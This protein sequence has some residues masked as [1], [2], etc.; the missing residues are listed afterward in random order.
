MT[1]SLRTPKRIEEMLN[2]RLHRLYALS[3]A[4]VVRLLEGRYGIARREWGLLALLAERGAMSP[5][6]LAEATQLDRPR[7]SRAL[8]VL[9]AKKL[10]LRNPVPADGR[11]ASVHLSAAG[12]RLV[13]ELLPQVIAFNTAVVAALD[14]AAVQALDAALERL[15][16]RA[17]RL[18][19]EVAL[20]VRADRRAGGRQRG[21]PATGR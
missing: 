18:N 9:V 10:V 7:V 11:R 4:P 2:F 21:R 6:A 5:S 14:D 20:D 1:L 16:E 19:R 12:R 8:S 17:R 3:G 15:T 13:A